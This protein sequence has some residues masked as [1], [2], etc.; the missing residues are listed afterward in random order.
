M[1][2]AARVAVENAESGDEEARARAGL[3][4]AKEELEREKLEADAAEGVNHLYM[5]CFYSLSRAC[6]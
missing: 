4:H 5:C 1:L 2:I 6:A 3:K